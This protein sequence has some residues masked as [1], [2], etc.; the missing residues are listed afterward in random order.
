M[1]RF[2]KIAVAIAALGAA[3]VGDT[4]LFGVTSNPADNGTNSSTTTTIA[5]PASMLANDLAIIVAQQRNTGGVISVSTTGGQTWNALATL[6]ASSVTAKVFWCN[7]NGTWDASPIVTTNG[8]L[9]ETMVMIVFR[10]SVST[11]TW[12]VNQAQVELLDSTDPYNIVGQTTTGSANTVTLAGWLVAAAETFGSL[13]G[14]G[15]LKTGLDAQY[16]NLGGSDQSLSLAYKI[17][18]AAGA[19][20]DVQQATGFSRAHTSFIVSFNEV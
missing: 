13:T 17:Q 3:V 11:K 19:T 20:G 6:G 7:F 5:P 14:A 10:P 16:R 18:T 9:A 1:R 8:G 2:S 12:A 4:T 15:W